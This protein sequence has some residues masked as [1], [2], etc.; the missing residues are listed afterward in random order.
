MDAEG[1]IGQTS[2]SAESEA[3]YRVSNISP[4]RSRVTKRLYHTSV[5][6]LLVKSWEKYVAIHHMDR[7]PR[8]GKVEA[9]VHD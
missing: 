4:R 5:N 1:G 2:L 8:I 9:R 6:S 7:K 3:G